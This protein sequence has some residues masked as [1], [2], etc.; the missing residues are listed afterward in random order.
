M[1][2][3][4]LS[5]SIA[6]SPTAARQS[7][8]W[9][10]L[11]IFL[12]IYIFNYAD[13]YLISGLVE[14]IKAEF[15]LGDRF[16]GLLMGPA[17][18]VFYTTI[19]I[20]V[21]RL[22]DRSSRIAIIC[23]GGIVWSLFTGLSGL[24]TGPWTLALARVGVGVGEAAFAAPAYSILADYFRPE[25][26]SMAF[27]ILGLAIYLGQI[28]GYAVGPIIADAHSWRMAF[29]L[30][31]LPGILLSAVAWFFVRE[32]VRKQITTIAN[33]IPLLPLTRRLARTSAF[34]LMMVG[35]GLG[36]LSGVSF[37]FWGP[38]LFSR[39]YDVPLTEASSTFGIYFGF[40]GLTG[41][42]LFGAV[43]DRI[44]KR[45]LE[46][47]LLLAA[48]ALFAAS[49]CIMLV[50]WSDSLFLAKIFA[51]PSGLLGGGWAIGI[52][53]SLQYLLPDR[54]RA[55]GTALFIMVTTFLGFVIGPWLTGALSQYFGDGAMSLRWALTIVIPTGVLGAGMA[56]IAARHL[57]ADR[58]KLERSDPA[59]A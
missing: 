27:A 58:V 39:L 33:Q 41:T 34:A 7:N 51:I 35:M 47:P 38:T 46:R 43:A 52:M 30:M 22:A 20:P 25:R 26:R 14:P 40:A 23:V 53:A 3:I 15:G 56:W 37:G 12:L 2:E 24:A 21:A 48:T 18:A 6:A 19:A 17:F 9:V 10:V 45:G 1:R 31:T 54:F 49:V 57:E 28:T 4:E 32:P 59:T 36:T 16:M 50:T 55:T 44:A 8:A 5:T 29:Y 11:A 42:L 13:R